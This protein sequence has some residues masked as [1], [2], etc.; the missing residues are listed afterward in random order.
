MALL[1]ADHQVGLDPRGPPRGQRR[2]VIVR[3]H[4]RDP[5]FRG[6]N[7][8]RVRHAGDMGGVLVLDVPLSA[9]DDLLRCCVGQLAHR[10]GDDDVLDLVDGLAELLAP[11]VVDAQLH[12]LRNRRVVAIPDEDPDTGLDRPRCSDG[13]FAPFTAVGHRSDDGTVSMVV[14]LSAPAADTGLAVNLDGVPVDE[15]HAQ[16]AAES[17]RARLGVTAGELRVLPSSDD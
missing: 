6:D 3:C 17:V 15:S 12:Y 2:A 4:S 13:S 10:P 11:V 7:Q 9:L 16:L 1:D 8:L 5:I 14:L